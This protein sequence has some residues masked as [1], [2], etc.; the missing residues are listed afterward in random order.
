ME[1]AE[2]IEPTAMPPKSTDGKD[3][4]NLAEFPL[5][6]L[7]HRLRPDQKTLRFQDEV[8]DKSRQRFITRQLTVTGSDAFGLP[9]PLDDEVLLGLIQLTR[10]RH[11]AERK[12]PFTRH[13]LLRILGWRDESK[14]YARIEASLNRWTGVTLYYRNA[15]WSRATQCW[16][17]EKFHILDN[18]WLCHRDAP[19]P[20]TGL[21]VSGAQVSAF[22]WNEVVFRSFQSGNLKGIDLEFFKN[23]HS[24]V[25]KR[26]YRFLDKHFR[27]RGRLEFDLRELA[28]EHVGLAHGYDAANLKRKLRPGIAELERKGFLQPIPEAGRFRKI[29]SGRWQVFFD[30]AKPGAQTTSEPPPPPPEQPLVAALT[31]RGVSLASAQKTVKQ[32]DAKRIQTQLEVFDWLLAHKDSRVGRNPPGFL[33]S[34]IRDEYQPPS[35]YT[36]AVAAREHT[37]AADARR[38]AADDARQSAEAARSAAEQD[39]EQRL[40]QF[41]QSVPEGE[42]AG[43][44]EAALNTAPSLARLLIKQGGLAGSAARQAALN[45]YARKRLSSR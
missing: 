45:D 6:A 42:K 16:M 3:E 31:T 14:S 17:D 21:P 20:D 12:V 23:L 9:T 4:L 7:T 43:A 11:F 26:L 33:V 41:W 2:R 28:C 30:A 39:E 36:E 8:W 15:W 5:C 35:D 32:F 25:A 10:L 44:E 37:Q 13:Q 40:A 1:N 29:C 34:A 27:Q 38:R 22:V 24:A 19:P 18:V